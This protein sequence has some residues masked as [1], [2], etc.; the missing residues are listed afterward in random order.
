MLTELTAQGSRTAPAT[1]PR[2]RCAHPRRPSRPLRT[3]ACQTGSGG[4]RTGRG[5]L[6]SHAPR[7]KAQFPLPGAPE[8]LRLPAVR[9]CAPPT[10][11]A[12]GLLSPTS[13]G[14]LL[15]LLLLL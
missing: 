13:C 11:A 12:E 8:P 6:R 2:S 15:L 14:V 1:R 7:R 4:R 10:H 9:P 3:V 5:L